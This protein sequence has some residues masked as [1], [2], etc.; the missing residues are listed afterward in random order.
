MKKH[1]TQEEL[2]ERFDYCEEGNL[3]TLKVNGPKSYIG[4]CVGTL[5]KSTGR[6]VVRFNNVTYDLHQLIWIWHYGYVP[7]GVIDHKDQDKLNNRYQNLRDVSTT[8]NNR[9]IGLRESN[10]AGIVGVSFHS[11]RGYWRAVIS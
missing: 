9:N 1:P 2:W 4:K 5:S 11:Q 3:I 7:E 10:T 6:L 8:C